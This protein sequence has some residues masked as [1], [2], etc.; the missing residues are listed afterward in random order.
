VFSLYHLNSPKL[1][2]EEILLKS[3]DKKK[4]STTEMSTARKTNKRKADELSDE[5]WWE[6]LSPKD[7]QLAIRIAHQCDWS[8]AESE[9]M[10]RKEWIQEYQLFIL[11]KIV[12]SDIQLKE[13]SNKF[14]LSPPVEVETV[15]HEHLKRP[16]HY[17]KMCRLLLPN[18]FD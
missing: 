15:W 18:Q 10:I 4:Q 8:W 11:C 7:R 6:L 13:G 3:K 1:S 17:Y 5:N 14:S 2:I 16:L 12:A 9:P